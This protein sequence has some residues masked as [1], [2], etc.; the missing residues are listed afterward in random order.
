MLRKLI[1]DFGV[2]GIAPF[3]PKVA[4]V[5]VL[6][7]ITPF[8][9]KEDYGLYGIVTAYTGF[10]T[11]FYTLGLFVTLSNSFYRSR[12]QYKWL[13]RQVYGFLSLWNVVFAVIVAAVLYFVIPASAAENRWLI[14]A[15]NVL[16]LVFF[17]PTEKVATLYYQ[18]RR[19]PLQIGA[20][21]AIFG[22]LN[23]LLTLVTIRYLRI[24]YMGW[25]WS[26]FITQMLTNVSWWVPLNLRE[27]ITPIFNFKWR[28]IRQAM[29]VGLPVLPHQ[30]AQYVLDQSDRIVMDLTGVA[31][32]D[33][34][35]Y[36]V[37]YTGS[38]IFST[39]SL[40]YSRAMAPQILELIRDRREEILRKIIFGSQA[41]FLVA[42]VLY[43]CVA[44][45]LFAFLFRGEGLDDV[46]RLSVLICTAL[47]ST[48]MY[49]GANN[50]L[51]YHER[52]KT[53]GIQSLYAAGL[54]VGLNFLL[55]PRYGITAA[56]LTTFVSYQW[57]A[58]SRY[59]SAT[60]REVATLRYYPTR[61]LAATVLAAALAYWVSGL[62]PVTRL[63]ILVGTLLPVG[64]LLLRSR[65]L[66]RGGTDG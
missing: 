47:V 44:R 64:T 46:Y 2:Y 50:R 18:L 22:V 60:Y 54:N 16:P 17:G 56:A 63:V 38:Q 5:V 43:A 45:E 11:V 58:Y 41:L 53:I 31:T 1:G 51:F 59:Y 48:P 40:A 61:W 9:T 55:I 4:G 36:N 21:A 42:L 25:F 23:M 3:I 65:H 7:L 20:R 27:R 14:V 29:A 6:P 62:E 30:N 66:L 10:F 34:G 12:S 15:L 8:L 52:T 26:L 32:R 28:T 33:I 37:A 13:W 24:G 35:A 57:L 19:K 49:L 39:L